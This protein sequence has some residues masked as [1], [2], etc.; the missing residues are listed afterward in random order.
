MGWI[1]TLRRIAPKDTAFR[2]ITSNKALK[3]SQHFKKPTFPNP[4]N[5]LQPFFGQPQNVSAPSG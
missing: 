1:Q 4:L 2:E 3:E 5:H